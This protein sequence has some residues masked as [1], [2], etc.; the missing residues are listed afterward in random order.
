[1]VDPRSA[2]G[3]NHNH[4]CCSHSLSLCCRGRQCKST[5]VSHWLLLQTYSTQTVETLLLQL[6]LLPTF[7]PPHLLPMPCLYTASMHF[8][9]EVTTD[10][11]C[12][13]QGGAS[14]AIRSDW[15]QCWSH[16][17]EE[18]N[19]RSDRDQKLTESRSTL[20]SN[21]MLLGS[22]WVWHRHWQ[23]LESSTINRNSPNLTHS[24]WH[25]RRFITHLL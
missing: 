17:V 10:T 18:N 12:Q 11:Q 21:T 15:N 24:I 19:Q 5:A 13:K 9:A 2:A 3:S 20:V 16:V 14:L 7:P 22:P 8:V 4:N 6:T 23:K 25:K 1:M